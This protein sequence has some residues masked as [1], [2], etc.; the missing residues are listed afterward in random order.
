M[1]EQQEQEELWLDVSRTL[2]HN[3]YR[4]PMEKNVTA[5]YMIDVRKALAILKER[6]FL[7]PKNIDNGEENENSSGAE[8]ERAD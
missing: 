6:Y 8:K 1:T 5:V 7:V 3:K 4:S 2:V